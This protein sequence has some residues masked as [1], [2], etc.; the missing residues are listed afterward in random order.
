MWLPVLK[1]QCEVCLIIIFRYFKIVRSRPAL[2][3]NDRAHSFLPYV[4]CVFVAVLWTCRLSLIPSV[5]LLQFWDNPIRFSQKNNRPVD[6][7]SQWL[8]W[9]WCQITL[10][11]NV[12]V[13]KSLRSWNG[14][15]VQICANRHVDWGSP[16]AGMFMY[17]YIF[18]F[19]HHM[20]TSRVRCYSR[21]Q[22][23]RSVIWM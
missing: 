2:P 12:S 22:P 18:E 16:E 1:D 23:C 8:C 20:S 9:L 13:S 10:K 3:E 6:W 17:R 19:M 14:R 5:L 21:H 15:N 4:Q 7:A 11:N